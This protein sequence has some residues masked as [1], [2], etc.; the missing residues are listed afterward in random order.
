LV[1]VTKYRRGEL[2]SEHI[3]YLTEVFRNV[4]GDFGAT[5]VE[6]NGEDDHM[7]LLIEYPPKVPVSTLA[8]SLIGVP[9]RRLR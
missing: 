6:C 3:R 5:L 8:N 9:A 1:F 4:C 2:N 7:H